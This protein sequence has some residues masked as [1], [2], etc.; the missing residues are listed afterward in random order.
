MSLTRAMNFGISSANNECASL[1]SRELRNFSPNVL[2]GIALL[3]LYPLELNVAHLFLLAVTNAFF[4]NLEQG[5]HD[6][7]PLT[8]S[9]L[10]SLLYLDT[11]FLYSSEIP[12][13]P[14]KVKVGIC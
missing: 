5:I 6:S 7:V 1:T 13:L 11:S 8:L 4:E 14:W 2:G 3:Q 12:W 10:M 9:N